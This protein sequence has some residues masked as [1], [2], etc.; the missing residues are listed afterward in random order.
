MRRSA[1]AAANHLEDASARLVRRARV[2]SSTTAT[3]CT[4]RSRAMKPS[5]YGASTLAAS[6]RP[7]V[8]RLVV[9]DAHEPRILERFEAAERHVGHVRLAVPAGSFSR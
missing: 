1:D 3:R 4:D 8:A 2:S 5:M 6:W 9:A 7:V